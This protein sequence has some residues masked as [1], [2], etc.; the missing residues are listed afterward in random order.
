V[1]NT[2][3]IKEF[4]VAL[5]FKTDETAMKK[6]Q[7][8]IASA[9][10]SVLVL[11]AAIEG[12]AIAVA[13]GVARMAS[14]LEALYF[15]SQR[16]G[17]SANQ[18]QAFA[19]ASTNFGSSME[20]ALSAAENLAT[21]FR[22]NPGGESWLGG[23][24]AQ[25]GIDS[26]KL[27]GSVEWMKALSKLF[28]SQKASGQMFQAEQIA[29]AVG[30]SEHQLIAMTTPGYEGE[31]AKQERATRG[32]DSIVKAAHAFET[33]MRNFKMQ[34]QAMLFPLIGQ[35]M[36]GES[37]LIGKLSKFFQHH[38]KQLIKDIGILISFTLEML[39]KLLDWLDAHGNQIQSE[40][41]KA[42][43]AIKTS[44]EIVKPAM[45]WLYNKFVE[46]D[47]ATDG[48]ST[49][50]LAATAAL[51][52]LGAGGIVDGIAMLGAGLAKAF[53]SFVGYAATVGETAPWTVAGTAFGIAAG[54][55]IGYALGTAIY[56]FLPD[57]GSWKEK[58]GDAEGGAIAWLSNF[59]DQN[60]D[61]FKKW[62]ED[63][64]KHTP[65]VPFSQI[66]GSAPVVVNVNTTVHGVN[67]QTAH[68]I[69][70]TNATAVHNAA[71]QAIREFSKRV[72]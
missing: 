9:T 61:Q 49:R 30:I 36:G 32:W 60:V 10:R 31:L 33:M 24:L 64:M 3:T 35:V 67:E 55:A 38:G 15:A 69:A 72:Q 19:L 56:Q 66:S 11:G 51:K 7:D 26:E 47:R 48:W 63:A 46:L 39:G 53:G 21:F 43:K 23:W 25:I 50:L 70:S 41:D 68:H 6:F 29:G 54:A 62:N 57:W 28:T 40:I 5:G 59:W 8:G 65:A 17:S 22:K 14:N 58:L 12:A 44:Y 18:L 27:H 1:A 2:T 45:E 16:T 13:V 20:E 71:S 34:F 42:F 37:N 52:L 4:L